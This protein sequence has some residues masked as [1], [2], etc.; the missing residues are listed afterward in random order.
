MEPSAFSLSGVVKEFPGVRALDH[1]S[2]NVRPGEVHGLVGENG[3]GKSTVIKVLAGVY[4]PEAGEIIVG[5]TRLEPATPKTVHAAGVRFIHQELHLVPHFTVTES[6]FMGQ[7]VGGRLG[8]AKRQMRQRAET[9][10][11]ENLGLD[12]SGNRLIRDLGTAERKLVQIARALIDGAAK[13]VVFDEPTA[14]LAS[15]EVDTVM[16][17]IA[18]LKEQGIAIL[19]VSHYLSEITDICDRVTVFRQGE[20]VGVFD[21]IT[22]ASAAD[23][24]FAMVGR[25]ISDMFPAKRHRKTSLGLAVTGLSDADKFTD[26]SLNVGGGEILGIAGL[27]GSGREELVDTLYGLRR[28][29]SGSV[30]FDGTSLRI[31]TAA[32]AVRQGVALV[33]RD[34]R[35]DGLVLPMTVTENATLATLQDTARVGLIDRKAAKSATEDQ[36]KAL[37]IRPPNADNVTRLLSGGNQQKVVLARW[38]ST[39]ARLFIFDEPTVGVDVGAK[40]EI[41]QLIE[42]LAAKGAAVIVSSSDPVELQGVC[43]RII[44]MMRGRNVGTLPATGLSID[45]LVA[46]TTG[47][48]KV[49]DLA[50][51]G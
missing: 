37:D 7:E 10:L 51:A 20:T 9:F 6:V 50:N 41:Y 49:E 19:Y 3:A 24:I 27:I 13:V 15:E 47:A 21:A 34:R 43:D 26:V 35:H 25:E 40:A 16:R 29:K 28:T 48:A 39:N 45:T 12:I 5:G 18:R 14:P 11:R 23:L 44:V 46:A 17:A 22:D 33:P 32:Q 38:L 4:Q 8:L 31:A 42:D 2:L 1:A 30:F 36:I